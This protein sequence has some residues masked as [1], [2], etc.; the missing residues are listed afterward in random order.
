MLFKKD[1]IILT[2]SKKEENRNL[3]INNF[4]LKKNIQ[5]S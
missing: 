2:K 5:I 4:I 3:N 1:N